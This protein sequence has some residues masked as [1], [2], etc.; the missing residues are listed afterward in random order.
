M[1]TPGNKLMINESGTLKNYW[2]AAS[3]SQ[4]VKQNKP[5]SSVILDVPVVI[6]RNSS[7]VLSAMLD[8]CN[9]RNAPLSEGKIINDCLVCPYHGWEYNE[10]GQCVKI[11]SEG[12][13]IERIPNKKVELFPVQEKYDIIWVWMGRD[14]LP[15]KEPFEMPLYNS[16]GWKYYYMETQ[17]EN[18]VTDLVE[19]FMDIPHT[20]YVHKG[21]FRD[22]KQMRIDAV[23]ERTR[24][25]VLVSYDQPNDTIGFFSW[26]LNPKRL[27]M[28]HT[29]NFYM[30]N[31][32]RVDYTYGEAER[33]FIITS[34]CTPVSAFKTKVFT[35]ITYKFGWINPIAKLF[36]PMYT[37]KVIN[38]D[39]WVMKIHGDNIK[40]F[41][42][43]DYKSTQVDFMHVYIE[44]L[45]DWAVRGDEELKP[46]PIK[47]QIEFWV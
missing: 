45:R 28:K 16:G 5:F 43:I 41:K 34:T 24:D 10:E 42:S 14:N 17:F 18:N 20:V 13:H 21:W 7:G 47:K 6:W 27:P 23:V 19:N 40:R 26:L 33:A 1:S 35:L 39:V 38:Q 22:P 37:R 30:P 15:D 29:D 25:S 46:Q 36:L 3:L 11:P 44:S 9:H 4:Q 12:P 32:T 2:Y 31:N 8:R